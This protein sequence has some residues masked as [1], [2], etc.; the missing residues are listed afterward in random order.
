M[1]LEKLDNCPK[2]GGILSDT[3]RCE[4]CGAK[5]YDLFDIDVNHPKFLRIKWNNTLIV[6]KAIPNSM[7]LTMSYD[8]AP[9]LEASFT[10]ISDVLAEYDEKEN[11]TD[12]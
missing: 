8:A 6:C 7:S 11:R 10:I 5:V 9:T 1:T 4:Y 3:G 2:C 12:G